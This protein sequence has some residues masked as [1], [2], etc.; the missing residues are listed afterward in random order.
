MRQEL[1]YALRR[2]RRQAGATLTAIATLACAIGATAATWTLVSATVLRPVPGAATAGWY[3]VHEEHDGRNPRFDV[4]YPAL[5]LVEGS[6]AFEQVEAAWG[7]HE[8][9]RLS[10]HGASSYVRSAFVTHRLLPGL[11]VRLQLGRGFS[12]AEDRR[13]AAPVALLTLSLIHI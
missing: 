7:T 4:A 8:H 3:A 13:G 6:G 1:R 5:R 12:A 10:R 11:G 9:L 2:L